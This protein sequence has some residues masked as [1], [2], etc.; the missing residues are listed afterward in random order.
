MKKRP[1]N[2][3]SKLKLCNRCL[4]VCLIL[5]LASGIQ[6]EATTGRYIWSV[7]TH[8]I[9][10]TILIALSLYHIFLH[11]KSG[12]W[13][14]RFSKNRNITTRILWWTFLLTAISGLAATALWL[15][16][17]AHS[18][19]GAIHGKIGFLMILVAILHVAKHL[20]KKSRKNNHP[21]GRYECPS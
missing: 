18:H 4:G 6:L 12:N 19:L 7:W 8:I 13:F 21:H 20:R 9:F 15:N 14:S 10:G 16:G 3:A 11:Y 1:T 2:P 17:H 5:M